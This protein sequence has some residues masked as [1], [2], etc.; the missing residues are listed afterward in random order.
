[1]AINDLTDT[2]TL[3][4]LLKYDSV[5]GIFPDKISYDKNYLKIGNH[6]IRV[7]AEKHPENLPWK[8]L[9]IDIV[10]EST[11]FFTTEKLASKHLHVGAKRVLISA[12]YKGDQ[13][14]KTLIDGVNFNLY[15]KKVDKIISKGSCTTNCLAPIVKVLDSSLGIEKAFM[16]T[17]HA[18]TSTQRIVDSPSSDFRKGRSLIDNLIPTKTGA[19]VAICRVIPRLMGKIDG[20]SIRV[21]NQ[22]G[23][24]VDL[25]CVVK[26]PTSVEKVNKLFEKASKTNMKGI[27]EY[28]EDELT[29]RDIIGNRHAAIFDPTLTK[30]EGNLIKVL[31]WYDNEFGYSATLVRLLKKL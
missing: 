14:I 2:K 28:N 11:G 23:S 9:K 5:Y 8:E 18:V 27:I 31:A 13:P 12:N 1:M 29:A 24:I 30:V 17:V 7:F 26:R 19:A 6:K 25:T 10:I 16:T 4:Y 22:T 21:P 3:A 20:M 15:N